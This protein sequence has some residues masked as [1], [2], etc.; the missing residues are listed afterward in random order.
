MATKFTTDEL[1]GGMRTAYAELTHFYK[2][3]EMQKNKDHDPAKAREILARIAAVAEI[4][5]LLQSVF[6][7]V[8]PEPEDVR[9]D[10]EAA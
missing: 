10:K 3:R 5:K 9:A 8:T 2:M 7:K 6:E 1:I 4:L